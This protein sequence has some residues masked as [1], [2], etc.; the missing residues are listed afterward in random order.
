MMFDNN[1]LDFALDDIDAAQILL[2]EKKYN[3]TCF[4]S[5]QAAE[6][7]LKGFLTH[8]K[9]TTPRIHNLV[10]LIN[11]CAGIDS[12]FSNF[13]PQM[14]VLNQ[15]YAPTRY[16]DAAVG[17]TP[18]GLPNQVLAEKALNYADEVVQFCKIKINI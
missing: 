13:I 11:L 7:A 14:A 9:I 12:E 16:P 10:E 8:K 18:N 1:W 3:M 2:R 17:M 15:F 5:Q 6:K 4:H